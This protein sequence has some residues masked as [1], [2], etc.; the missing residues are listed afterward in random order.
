MP[1]DTSITAPLTPLVS[2]LARK[3]QKTAIS[4]G[5][6]PGALDGHLD[7][8]RR[9]RVGANAAGVELT[10]PGLASMPWPGRR[11]VLRR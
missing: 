10:A 3:A 6:E 5:R 7:E 4:S 1:P 11:P 9:H 8:A 2:S